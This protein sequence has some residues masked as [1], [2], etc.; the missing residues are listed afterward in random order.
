M[1]LLQLNEHQKKLIQEIANTLLGLPYQFGAEVDLKLSP[2]ELKEKKQPFDCSELV[3]YIFYQIGYKIPDGSYNQYNAS[4]PVNNIEI[5]D[6]VFKREK[7]TKK[8]CHSGIII[9][10]KPQP[11]VL[12]AEGWYKKI[13]KRTLNSFMT[14]STK[15]EFAGVRRLNMDFVKTL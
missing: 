9:E 11:I 7:E 2:K 8:I 3:E 4:S 15:T 6:L 12:E 5:G 13:I 10:E 1:K 14:P